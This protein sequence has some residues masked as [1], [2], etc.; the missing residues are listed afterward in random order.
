M[1]IVCYNT[2]LFFFK[3]KEDSYFKENVYSMYQ[4]K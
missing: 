4:E 2:K 3:K 1:L